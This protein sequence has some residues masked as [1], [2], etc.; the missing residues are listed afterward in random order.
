MTGGSVLGIIEDYLVGNKSAAPGDDII[1]TKPI[2]TQ[3]AIN[4][5]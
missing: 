3:I 1:L 4:I 5:Q 2:G